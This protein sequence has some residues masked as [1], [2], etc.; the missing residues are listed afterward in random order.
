[1]DNLHKQ[2]YNLG[3][4]YS[5]L[6]QAYGDNDPLTSQTDI[7][8][9]TRNPF[10]AVTT[11]IKNLSAIHKLTG[12][13]NTQVEDILNDFELDDVLAGKYKNINT[14]LQGSWW[15]GFYNAKKPLENPIKQKRTK[16]KISQQELADSVGV[17]QKTVSRWETGITDP[18]DTQYEQIAKILKC[19]VSDIK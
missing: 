7:E 5:L 10:T 16:L 1:M 19:D 2:V 18:T 3:R 13:V 15:L 4:A 14:E 9:A 6:S 11:A 17:S 12:D 8:N